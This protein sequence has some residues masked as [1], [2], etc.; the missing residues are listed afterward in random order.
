MTALEGGMKGLE[1]MLGKALGKLKED[2]PSATSGTTD[3]LR[4]SAAHP[5]AMREGVLGL[6]P[7]DPGQFLQP[8]GSVNP[9]TL[10]PLQIP[11]NQNENPVRSS[12]HMFPGFNSHNPAMS[13][14]QFAMPAFDAC[15]NM[16]NTAPWVKNFM[17]QE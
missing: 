12:P 16:M 14:A 5:P 10:H 11:L 8:S 4:S 9:Q 2:P 3:L 15:P 7:N 17:L 13:S 1:V 6:N